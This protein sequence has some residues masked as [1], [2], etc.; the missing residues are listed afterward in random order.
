[1]SRNIVHEGGSGSVIPWTNGTGSDVVVGSIVVMANT[2]GV[3]LVNIANTEVGSVAIGGVVRDVAKTT[4]TAWAQGEAL[5]WDKST[6]KFN[7]SGAVPAAGD[8]TGGAIAWLAAA[9]GDAT[10]VIKLAP[11][12]TAVA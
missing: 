1:M 2:I 8:V 10:G 6:S 7:G 3:A 5:V 4:G 12:N 11:G 9:S